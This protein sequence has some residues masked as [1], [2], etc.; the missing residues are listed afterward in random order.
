MKQIVT[1]LLS[2]LIVSNCCSKSTLERARINIFPKGE[3]VT[4]SN[5]I[6]NVW[7]QMLG[8]DEETLNTGGVM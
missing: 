4:N 5:F 6:D 3:K 1:L 8:Q 7:V 2:I